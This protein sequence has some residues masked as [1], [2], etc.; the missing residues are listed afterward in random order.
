[1]LPRGKA[2]FSPFELAVVAPIALTLRFG[3]ANL[4]NRRF[5][6]V[7]ALNLHYLWIR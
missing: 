6:L 2:W 4:K 3:N 7:I 5:S 1:M